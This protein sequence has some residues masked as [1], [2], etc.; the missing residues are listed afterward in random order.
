[1]TL[2]VELM[3]DMMIMAVVMLMTVVMVG[4]EVV[5]C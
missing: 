4:V 3:A 5:Y 1:M 2:T